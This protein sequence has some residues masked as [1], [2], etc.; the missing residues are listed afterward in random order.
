MKRLLR[1]LQVPMISDD[2]KLRI[3][4]LA[5]SCPGEYA[6]FF[7]GNGTELEQKTNVLAAMVT[8]N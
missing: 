5:L 7:A 2:Q 4:R 1:L 6:Q 8:S 3:Y